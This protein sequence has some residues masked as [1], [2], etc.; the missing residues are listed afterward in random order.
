[1]EKN[2]PW[3]SLNLPFAHAVVT[4]FC[5]LSSKILQIPAFDD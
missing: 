4:V 1:M 3:Q 5:I 2:L